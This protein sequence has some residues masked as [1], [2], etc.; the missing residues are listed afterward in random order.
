M[1]ATGKK[2]VVIGG[3]FG[4]VNAA[5]A[6]RRALGRDVAI[7]VISKEAEFTFL[8]SLPWVIMGWR[9]PARLQIP[10][11]EPLA[12]RGIRFVHAAV[13]ELN[14]AKNEVRAGNE[15]F[16]YD[17][18][19]VATGAQLD[20]AAVP[21]TGP[22]GGHT[23]STF[24]ATEASLARDALARVLAAERGRIVIGAAAGASCI[25]PAYELVLMIDAVLRRARRR[26][27]FRLV[28]VTPEPFLGHFGMG[29]VGAFPRRIQDEFAERDIEPVIN[30]KIVEARRD[31]LIVEGG[32]EW[33][34]DFALV[35]PAFLGASF[36]R[37]VDGLTNPKG[38][39]PVTPHLRSTKFDNIYAVGVAVAIPPVGPTPVPVNVPKT[40]HLTEQM[41][42]A[43]AHNIAAD[44]AG[45]EKVDGLTVPV[46]CIADAG[47]TAYYFHADPFLPPRNKVVYR[48][49][50]M[51]RHLKMAFEKYYLARIR[52]DWP[53]LEFGW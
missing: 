1:S 37:V 4:G 50:K 20:Y 27:Q 2:I 48:E 30:A 18:L 14:P 6:L 39:I 43:A 11:A 8:P 28:F 52:H 34:F 36:L 42:Q 5:Y 25:G 9:D 40:G 26:H 51:G 41:A 23:H 47:D 15:R 10:L 21:G 44:F 31:R 3:S 19:V 33:L 24:T 16:A 29:G 49:G 17:V 35:I 45:G 46:T 38:F 12:R 7:T 22:A 32:A 13:E 53:P